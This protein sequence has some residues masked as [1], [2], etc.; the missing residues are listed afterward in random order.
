MT[1][2]RMMDKYKFDPTPSKMPPAFVWEI[3]PF[4]TDLSIPVM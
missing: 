3:I 2:I 4:S 1:I